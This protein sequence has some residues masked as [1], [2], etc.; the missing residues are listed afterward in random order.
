MLALNMTPA[1]RQHPP[2]VIHVPHASP[3]IPE[4]VRPTL[5]LND[6]DLQ[7]ELR[8][9]TD[10]YTDDLFSLPTH[11]ATSVVFPVS[12]LVVDPE[13]FADDRCEPMAIKGMGAIY[14]RTSAG[15]VLRCDP[16]DDERENLL[17]TYYYPHHRS[18]AT[19]IH[20]A[21]AV[22]GFSLM[23]DAHSFSSRPLD[24]EPDQTPNRCHICLGTDDFHTPSWLREFLKTAFEKLDY[25]VDENRPF[26]G[27][28]VPPEFCQENKNV[29]S[30]MIEINRS[31]YMDQVTGLRLPG[32][33]RCQSQLRQV[34]LDLAA[35]SKSQL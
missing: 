23:V 5:R 12:R 13:R 14:V 10:W 30:V 24:H 27:T 22:H 34:L 7:H 15:R 26:S 9:M 25:A 17:N 3:V 20:D 4:K 21:L 8:V 35:T 11:L 31:L 16:S 28:L 1:M 32:F 29:L 33:L 19:A 2:L 18:L 6:D